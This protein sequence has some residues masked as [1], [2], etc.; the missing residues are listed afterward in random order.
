VFVVKNPERKIQ[1]VVGRIVSRFNPVKIVLFG[2]RARKRAHASSDADLLI[3]MPVRGSRRKMATKIDMALFG[4]R[5]PLDLVVVTPE[6]VRR[7][8]NRPGTIIHTA[9]KEGITVHERAAS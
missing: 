8:R 1:E 4:I 2:S 7:S 5:I 3:I 6:D 9:L